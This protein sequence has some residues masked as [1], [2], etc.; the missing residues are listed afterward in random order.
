MNLPASERAI[1][2]ELQQQVIAQDMKLREGGKAEIDNDRAK[3]LD[4]LMKT[5]DTPEEALLKCS[6]HFELPVLRSGDNALLACDVIIEARKEQY[7]SL[8]MKLKDQLNRAARLMQRCESPSTHYMSWKGHVRENGFGDSKATKE[9]VG[10]IDIAEAYSKVLVETELCR[11]NPIKKAKKVIIKAPEKKTENKETTSAGSTRSMKPETLATANALELRNLA[12]HLR[13]LSDELVSRARALRF[14]EAVHRVQLWQTEGGPAPVCAYCDRKASAP[15]N[16]IVLG[17]CGHI[18]CDDCLATTE[19]GGNCVVT[20]CAAEAYDYHRIKACE[21]RHKD[22]VVGSGL[23]CG[24]KVKEIIR[25]IKNVPAED[26]VLLFV[27]FDG[28]MKKVASALEKHGI[29]HYALT[30]KDSKNAPTWMNEFQ[31]NTAETRKKVLVL[32]PSNESAAGA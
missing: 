7:E 24:K 15:E 4:D 13:S 6:S 21:L 20:G 8:C 1:L 3:R 9:L 27:Q 30:E 31:E 19:A 14:F 5:S 25:L 26:Q 11:N 22:P 28:L 10:M 32:N 29:S 18:V 17:L 23:V 12:G 16:I 2:I